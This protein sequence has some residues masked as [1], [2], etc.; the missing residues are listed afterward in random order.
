MSTIKK[1][2]QGIIDALEY[3][4]DVPEIELRG[5]ILFLLQFYR[6]LESTPEENICEEI[7]KMQDRVMRIVKEID[8]KPEE[9]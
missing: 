3:L 2:F 9:N 1:H 6:R 8:Q 7:K 5:E 4:L